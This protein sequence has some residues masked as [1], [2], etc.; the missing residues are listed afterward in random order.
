ML[1][2]TP[3]TTITTAVTTLLEGQNQNFSNIYTDFVQHRCKHEILWEKPFEY[4]ILAIIL[5]Y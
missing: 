5:G 3:T 1:T 2:T 4:F